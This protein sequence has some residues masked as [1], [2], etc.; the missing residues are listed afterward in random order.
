MANN[1]YS[2]GIV[3]I[4]I[5]LVL[6]LGKLGVFHFLGW[7]LWPLIVGAIGLVFHG[8]Y[9]GKIAPAGVLIPGGILVTYSI[10]FFLCNLFGW[11]LMTYLWP[12]FIFGVAVGLYEYQMFERYAPRGVMTAV[13]VL[14]IVSAAMFGMTLLFTLGIYFIAFGLLA[15]G[16]VLLMRRPKVW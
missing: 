16:A 10:M 5:A 8:L 12:G 14:T 3:L 2:A 6:L 11:H 7:L 4:A 1:R 13:L 15:G 9:F